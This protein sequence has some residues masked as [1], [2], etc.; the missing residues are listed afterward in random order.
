MK[1]KLVGAMVAAVVLLSG[2]ANANPNVAA[3]IG[4]ES[5]SVATV[6]SVAKVVASHSPDM[7]NWGNWRAP[8]LQVMIISRL[9]RQA[10]AQAGVTVTDSQRESVYASAESYAALAKDP[11]SAAFMR[12]FADVSIVLSDEKGQQA[13]A[14]AAAAAPVH[15]NPAFGVWDPT[16]IKLTGQTGSLSTTLS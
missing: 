7:P 4:A 13:F 8:V 14:A 15:M 16:Q 9:A 6:D 10:A 2:C 3:T 1:K 12:D 11:G 5:I